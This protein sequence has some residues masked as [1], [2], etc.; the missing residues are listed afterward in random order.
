MKLLAALGL[1]TSSVLISSCGNTPVNSNLANDSLS[2]QI[3]NYSACQKIDALINAYDNDFE[4]I[5]LNLLDSKISLIWKAKYNL[6]GN[7][8]KI[9]SWGGGAQGL[10]Y[11][12]SATAPNKDVAQQYYEDAKNK[13]SECLDDSWAMVESPSKDNEG[14][15]VDF[16]NT[17]KDIRISTHMVP[18]G[19]WSR[20]GWNVYY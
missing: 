7:D 14:L 4:K 13:A 19:G 17:A 9:W 2:K 11:S 16:D 12:C 5:K 10:T 15:K 20:S 1:I 8:C 3:Q 6:V 18:T